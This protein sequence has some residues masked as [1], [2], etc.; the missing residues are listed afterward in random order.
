MNVST[1]IF[2]FN[3]YSASGALTFPIISTTV[4]NNQ[5]VKHGFGYIVVKP[6]LRP[7]ESR[8]KTKEAMFLFNDTLSTFHLASR[9]YGYGPYS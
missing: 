8:P 3:I 7:V 1:F 5:V 4:V 2:C 6:S 9:I